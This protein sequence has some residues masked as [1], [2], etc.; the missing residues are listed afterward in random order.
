MAKDD[1]SHLTPADAGELME[2]LRCPLSG[3]WEM[4]RFSSLARTPAKAKAA[5]KEYRT[6]TN[7]RNGYIKG[8]TAEESEVKTKTRNDTKNSKTSAAHQTAKKMAGHAHAE[9]PDA[10]RDYF[11]EAGDPEQLINQML[12]KLGP[13][14]IE[15]VLVQLRIIKR[16]RRP[17]IRVA[18]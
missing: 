4:R 14:G 5:I 11:A 18:S 13:L 8:Y 17:R 9:I 6:W 1:P 12:I 15:D 16:P 10:I 3:I 2:I 7:I